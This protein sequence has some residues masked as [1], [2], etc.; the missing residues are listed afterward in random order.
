MVGFSTLSSFRLYTKGNL[1]LFPPALFWY[2]R[3]KSIPKE[4]TIIPYTQSQLL[5]LFFASCFIGWLWESLYVSLRQKKW[6]NRGFLRGPWLPIYGLGS[7]TILLVTWP[8]R[9]SFPLTYL[10]GM[11]AATL[12]EGLTGLVMEWLFHVRLWDYSQKP[13]NWRG[14]VCLRISLAWGCFSLLL[15][16]VIHPLLE[17]LVLAL[18]PWLAES[19]SLIL[20]VLFAV[21]A[22]RSVQDALDL[23]NILVHL[24][25]KFSDKEAIHS[26]L[27]QNLNNWQ[28]KAF[29][30]AFSLLRRNPDTSSRRHRDILDALRKW[31]PTNKKRM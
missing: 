24:Q 6:V 30:H 15:V 1:C 13:L 31:N 9:E 2:S 10:L 29:H 16:Q 23:K 11:A 28:A 25:E 7:L 8:V 18:P 17:G 19:L 14:Y 12:V 5:L 4:G 3:S 20:T 27:L 22:T 21:D 26:Q